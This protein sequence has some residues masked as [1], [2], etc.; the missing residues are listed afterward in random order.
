MGKRIEAARKLVEPGKQYT[1]PEAV[2]LLKKAPAPKFDETVEVALAFDVDPKQSDQNVRGTVVLPHGTGNSVRVL[3]FAKGDAE[4]QAKEAG[5]DYVGAED[6]MAKIE[7]GWMDFDAVVS[8]PDLMREVGKLGRVLGPRGLMPSPKAG[9]VTQD[10]GRTVREVKQGKV[11]FKMDKQ[12]DIHLGVG[13]RSF[14]NESLAENLKTILEA[15]WRA[16][17]A[18]AKGRYVESVVVSTTMGP[19][20]RLDPNE[21]KQQE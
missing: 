4:R 8:T 3:V 15:I 14:P 7:G 1:I 17:P 20:V 19:G 2:D 16:K 13:K 18:S 9:T 5:A 21:G 11:E 12:G 10:V 6:L